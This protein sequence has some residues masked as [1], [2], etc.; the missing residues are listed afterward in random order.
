MGQATGEIEAQIEGTRAE[1]GANLQE[2]EQKVKTVADWR[3]HFRNHAM[4]LMGVAFGGG[5][6]LAMMGGKRKTRV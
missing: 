4:T 3:H 6:L 2:L 5:V 1:L